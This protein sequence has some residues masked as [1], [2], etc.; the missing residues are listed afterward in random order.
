ME[1]DLILELIKKHFS[2]SWWGPR[3]IMPDA[4]QRSKIRW[5]RPG[6]GCPKI[7]APKLDYFH[8]NREMSRSSDKNRSENDVRRS[9]GLRCRPQMREYRAVDFGRRIRS[10][11][12]LIRRI[13]LF[14]FAQE[15]A[16][17]LWG[18]PY[19]EYLRSCGSGRVNSSNEASA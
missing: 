15:L 18:K 14:L 7:E 4:Q 16:T 17:G 9:H 8:T 13:L 19:L 11:I 5:K 1:T 6:D 2:M 12:C 3:T 10:G